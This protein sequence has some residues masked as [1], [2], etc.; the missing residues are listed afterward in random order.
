MLTA[1]DVALRFGLKRGQRSWRG[2]CPNCGYASGAFSVLET[3]EG[4]LR[5]FCAN[6]CSWEEL[7]RLLADATGHLPGGIAQSSNNMLASRER[8]QERALA[9][10]RGS[11]PASGTLA[12]RYLAA[13]GLHGLAASSSLRFRGDC[14]HP[15]CGQLPAL[16]ALVSDVSGRPQGVHRTYLGQDAK[17]ANAEPVR[18]SIGLVLG[19]A[20]K[21]QP[22][23][24][25]QAL[26]V[27]E[28][29][30]SSASAGRLLGLPAWAA[31]SAGNLARSLLVPPEVRRIV[32]AADPDEAGRSAAREA[33]TRWTA[34]GREVSIAL[35]DG[36]ADFNDLLRSKE[37]ANAS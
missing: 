3:K 18:A 13:R 35:P 24:E 25:G 22:V 17:K 30:E 23:A 15:E 2:R 16:V 32:I 5:L 7:R 33:W 36:P 1:K 34:E 28:G 37:A 8:R 19:C 12:D 9:I 14:P 31:L 27:G 11:E 4:R 10:W 21:L 29:I 20:I 6:G 26:I